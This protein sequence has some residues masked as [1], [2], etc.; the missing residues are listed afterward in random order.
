MTSRYMRNISICAA[1]LL[2]AVSGV[3]C[4]KGAETQE[5]ITAETDENVA[6]N[7]NGGDP[8]ESNGEDNAVTVTSTSDPDAIK[9]RNIDI[10]ALA[11]EN[12]EIF[13]W[14]TVP[15]TDIDCPILQSAIADDFY[16]THNSKKE[17]DESGA[18][19]IEMANMTNM[20]DF[21]TVI[22]GNGGEKG[23]FRELVNFENP[24]FFDENETFYI[25]IDGDVLTYEIW[26]CMER[27]NTSLIRTY[28]FTYASG[29]RQFMEDVYESKIVGKQIRNG[30]EQLSEY[31]FMVTLTIDDP[32]SDRQ[33]VVYGTLIEDPAGIIDRVIEE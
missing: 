11:A 9:S 25:Y 5:D 19:Y 27:D 7:E 12:E 24:D 28:D 33:L 21:N 22:H 8:S 16:M 31:N 20:C 3:G 15:G 17:A 30:W 18:L 1:A 23:L 2:L 10:P 4:G 29:C 6:V 32:D 13:G 26:G 14:L